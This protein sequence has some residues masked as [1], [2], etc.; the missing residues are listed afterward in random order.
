MR[1][2]KDRRRGPKYVYSYGGGGS[3]ACFRNRFSRQDAFQ[4]L[5]GDVF[6]KREEEVEEE[7]EQ[8]QEEEEEGGGGAA[9][10]EEEQE[11]EEEPQTHQVTAEKTI[12]SVHPRFLSFLEKDDSFLC[13]WNWCPN[14]SQDEASRKETMKQYMQL[15]PGS[16]FLQARLFDERQS[17]K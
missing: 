9:A 2:K 12:T 7:E 11:E 4:L 13:P 10:E 8:Q 14:A 3:G 1:R 16:F 17:D 5:L 6:Q 15:Q